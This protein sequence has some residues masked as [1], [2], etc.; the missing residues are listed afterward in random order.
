MKKVLLL[1]MIALLVGCAVP[2]RIA[3]TPSGKPEVSIPTNDIGL[4]KSVTINE[5]AMKGFMLQE[6]SSHSLFFTKTMEG[7][8]AMF[9]QMLIGNSYSTTPQSEIRINM[10]NYNDQVKLIA[11]LSMSTQMALGKVNRQDMS[12]NNAWFN[13]VQNLFE[14]VKA[15]VVNQATQ[16]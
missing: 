4:V 7:S 12:N 10:T 14:Q 13:D 16:P 9:A 8:Q 5:F 15:I 1:A 2:K 3:S 6:D 11:F